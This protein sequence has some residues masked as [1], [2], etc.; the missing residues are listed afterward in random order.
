MHD[1]WLNELYWCRVTR[2]WLLVCIGCPD[3]K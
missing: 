2:L 3:C 1:Y